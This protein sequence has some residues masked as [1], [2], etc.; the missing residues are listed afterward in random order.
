MPVELVVRHLADELDPNGRP[1]VVVVQPE[2][3]RA[4]QRPLDEAPEPG[5]DAVGGALVLHLHHAPR[6]LLV[7]SVSCFATTPSTPLPW[8]VASHYRV[9]ITPDNVVGD[10]WV[11][12]RVL[13]R[14]PQAPLGSRDWKSC[15]ADPA[16]G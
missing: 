6:S 10:T 7:G 14:M 11:T 13:M 8:Y 3:Q 12:R 16:R 4:R 15:N 5:D 2:Q 1:V 9:A